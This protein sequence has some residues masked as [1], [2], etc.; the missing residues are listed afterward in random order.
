M[1]GETLVSLR[2]VGQRRFGAGILLCLGFWVLH[3]RMTA[4]QTPAEQAQAAPSAGATT[5]ASTAAAAPAAP[6]GGTIRGVVVAGAAGKA[7]GIPLPG[8]AVT[9]TNTLTGKKYATATDIDGAYAMK[10]PRNGRYVVKVELAGFTAE[11]QEVVLN[12]VE[13]QAATQSIQIAVKP[14][15]FGM[16]L[17][18]RAAE[19]AARQQAAASSSAMGRGVQS[20]NLLEGGTGA[21]D[22]TGGGGNSG[23]PSLGG[24][25]EAIAGAAAESGGDS[26]AVSGAQGQT[27]GLANFSED[28]IRQRVEDAVAQG[29]ASGMIPQGGDPTNAIVGALG[30][31]MG[32]GGFGGG[33]RG[34]GGGGGRGGRGGGGGG[35]G[36][37]RNFN[38]AQPHGSIFYQGG[39]NALNASQWL[40]SSLDAPHFTP[41]P[42][43]YSNRYGVTIAASPYI[44]GLTKP[45]TK[46][47]VFINLTG[48]KNLTAFE[49]D[50]RVPTLL[51]RQGNFS[52]SVERDSTT[53]AP[54]EIYNP[55]TGLP[56]G[57]TTAG[58][59]NCATNIIPSTSI[60]PQAQA[61]L[62]YYPAPNLVTSDP[63][64]NNYQ[65]IANAGNNMVA[66]NARYVRTLGGGTQTPFGM[67]GGGRGGGR[68]GANAPPSLR[69]NINISYNFQHSASDQ[70]K[71]FLALGGATESNGYALNAGYVIGYGRL[72]NNASVTWNRSSSLTRNYFTN[73]P[74]DPSLS[75]G[76]CVPN[77]GTSGCAG[78]PEGGFAN[79]AFYNGLPSLSISSFTGLSV[80]TPSQTVNQTISF[81]DFVSYRHKKHNMRYGFDLRRLHADSIGGNNPLGSLSFTGYAT[82]S[83]SDQ[84]QTT[85]DNSGSAFADFLLGLPQTTSIQAGLYKDYLRENVFD[86]YATDDYRVASNWTL[87]FGVRY[88]YFGPYTEKNNRLINLTNVTSTTGIGCVS[89]TAVTDGGVTCAADAN[90][91]LVDADHTMYAP[92]FGF[93]YRPKFLPKLTKDTVVRGGYGINYNTGQY[94]T[95][96][97]L[98]SHQEPFAATESNTVPTPTITN[99]APSA[100]GCTTT[101]SAY[102]FTTSSGQTV[103]RPATTANMTLGGGFNCST[104]ESL[105][106]NWAVDPH[107]RLGMVQV[108]NLNIQRTIP[109]GIVLNVGYNGSKASGL[110][111]VGS[112]NGTPNGVTTPGVAAFDYEESQ[113]G[114]HSNQFV[115]SAQKRQQKG[116]ALGATYVYSHTIDNASGVS[117]AVGT[118]VQNFYRLDLEEGNSSF[119]QRHNLTGYWLYELPFGPNRALLNKGGAMSKVLD[120]FSISGNFTFATGTYFT[121]TYSGSQQEAAA[122]NTFTYRPDRVF[123]QPLHG[124][125]TLG[126]FFNTAAF[127][128]PASGQYGTASQGSIEG[129]GTVSVS[130]SLS[131]TVSLGQT[132]SF[133]ARVTATNVFNTVQYSGISTTEN[134]STFGQVTGAATMRTLLVQARYR[135]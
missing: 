20:L 69:Q 44:P 68:A 33:G 14:T 134:L 131:R 42:A 96:A 97:K 111:V 86:W 2:R 8:V 34:G 115:F 6:Q 82:E 85:T 59:I 66:I 71:I 28:E 83:A 43:G 29:R 101:Q 126:E 12:G 18:S 84:T 13:A 103:T 56:F 45:N 128:L 67:F 15:D 32:G 40:V 120:G 63:T 62:A 130:G 105:Q 55:A 61:L 47:F 9:A 95:F 23:V 35:F 118:A 122:A 132:R 104:L 52:Q 100:T 102:T 88:E 113:A 51:E 112:P 92:R 50:G 77:G 39:N 64:A 38:P 3:S 73:T 135:F 129:P 114:S 26:I 80:E 11:T 19:D 25:N 46:Q 57:C 123:S 121:P 36:N 107:Y 110:D 94:G 91:A 116:F 48:Q 78:G 76:I 119:D 21:E 81:S 98:L 41:N 74:N 125:G 117:G 1:R 87:N 16:E 93:A 75:A 49:A 10:I 124:P 4:A 58:Q 133:E 106:N 90:R 24:M 5:Q 79:A 30:G 108:Y 99:G 127:T 53:T 17:A 70:R 27:N 54:V 60:S 7:G 37:F 89:P 72:S 109:F 22:A 31:L 65:T